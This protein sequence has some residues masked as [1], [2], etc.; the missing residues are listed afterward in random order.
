M[1]GQASGCE[2]AWSTTNWF[3]DQLANRMG[4]DHLVGLVRGHINLGL[5]ARLN[6][7]KSGKAEVSD[8]YLIYGKDVQQEDSD[9]EMEGG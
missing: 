5:R 1:V 8:D 6:K 9:E 4:I 2:T 7:W 3:K